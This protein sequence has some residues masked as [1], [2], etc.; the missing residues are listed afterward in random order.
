MRRTIQLT[1]SLSLLAGAMHVHALQSQLEAIGT[2]TESG[3]QRWQIRV[4]RKPYQ[5]RGVG[6]ARATGANGTDYLLMAQKLGANTVRT[7]GL[8]HTD[9]AYLDRAAELGLQVAVGIWLPYPKSSTLYQT[10]D[11]PELLQLRTEI[12]DYVETFRNHPA[13]MLWV[14]GNE[15]LHVTDDPA[16][17][18]AFLRFLEVIVREIK[19]RDPD[20]LVTYA[21]TGS[22]DLRALK[23]FVPSLDLIGVNLYGDPRAMQRRKQAAGEPRPLLFTELGP[24]RPEDMGT[25]FLGYTPVPTDAEKTL[26]YQ[27]RLGQLHSLGQQS[28]GAFVFRLGDPKPDD[29]HWW[30]LS[31]GKH[32]RSSFA[33]VAQRYGG[34]NPGKIP[35][36]KAQPS[37]HSE[38]KA[39]ESLQLEITDQVQPDTEY[40]V[41]FWP[42]NPTA[43]SQSANALLSPE[44]VFTTPD[45]A[46]K[47]PTLPGD[48]WLITQMINAQGNACIQRSSLR[49]TP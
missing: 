14:V 28:L 12:L 4:D 24:R 7:W 8:T 37:K 33:A 35:T 43:R 10:P 48:Y 13:V 45:V 9:R 49:V 47:A 44:S 25:D 23:Q 16:E 6:C 42:I 34:V 36:C 1:L 11:T 30:N 32:P 27:R 26:R 38:V 22:V 19:Q 21:A 40:G 5:I 41:R 31:L 3:A 29:L 15:V 39:G 17:R 2:G 46:V 18:S 20:H